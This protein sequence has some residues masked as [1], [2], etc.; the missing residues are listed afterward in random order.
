MKLDIDIKELFDLKKIKF[1]FS[2]TLNDFAK[3]V[4][5]DHKRRLQFGQGVD[6]KPMKKLQPST[7]KSKRIKNYKNPR[8]P[9]NATSTMSKI[10]FKERATKSNQTATLKPAD[11]RDEIGVYH[12]EGGARLPKREWFGVTVKQEQKGIKLMEQRIEK[13]LK[14]V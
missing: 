14:R 11:S 12:Q 1:D 3:N 8:V 4:V 13:E 5:K 6:M 10:K 2:S 9:L 7:I